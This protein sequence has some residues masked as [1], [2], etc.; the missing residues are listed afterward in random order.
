MRAYLV[1]G[2]VVGVILAAQAGTLRG[3]PGKETEAGKI[4]R[5]IRQLGDDAFAK[6]EAASKELEAIGAL[7]L[8]AL[9]KAAASSDDPEIRWRAKRIGEAVTA[10]AARAELTRLQGVWTV[11]SYEIEGKQ[12]PGMDRRSTMT[13]TGDRWVAKWARQDGGVQVESGTLKIVNPDKAPLAVDF[14]H[15]GGPHKGSTV[16]AIS[17][18]DSG[19]FKFCYHVRAEARP[20]GFVTRAGDTSCGLVTYNRQKK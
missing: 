11:A 9:R 12:L 6:R 10:G 15:L 1:V 16:F 5:L 7:A 20:T 17:Q 19:T 13:I 4:V 18:V 8:A 2:A 3:D 14:M